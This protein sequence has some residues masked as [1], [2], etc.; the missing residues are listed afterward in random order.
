MDGWAMIEWVRHQQRERE[1]V[2]SGVIS[3]WDSNPGRC[4]GDSLQIL[5]ST[6]YKYKNNTNTKFCAKEGKCVFWQKVQVLV[7]R[8]WG[9]WEACSALHCHFDI[10]I[11]SQLNK[12]VFWVSTRM[13][14]FWKGKLAPPQSFQKIHHN[15]CRDF[16]FLDSACSH[17]LSG[18]NHRL[19][20][21]CSHITGLVMMYSGGAPRPFLKLMCRFRT[22]AFWIDFLW[23]AWLRRVCLQHYLSSLETACVRLWEI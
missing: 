15:P 16:P 18:L 14:I 9:L 22:L 8:H 10:F 1:R 13:C 4:S 21:N 17:I 6:K 12:L 20:W 5:R 23:W 3:G 19:A 2:S 7:I 11:L